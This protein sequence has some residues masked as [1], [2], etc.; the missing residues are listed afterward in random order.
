[1]KFN[2]YIISLFLLTFQISQAQEVQSQTEELSKI[3]EGNYTAYLTHKENGKYKG[4]MENLDYVLKSKEDYKIQPGVHQEIYFIRGGNPERRD[5]QTTLLFLPDNEA[6]PVTYIERFYEGNKEMQEELGYVQRVNRHADDNRLVFLDE[7]IYIIN[8]W[9]DKDH[10]DLEAVL[11]YEEKPI[12]M[13]KMMKLNM[14]SPK[15]MAELQPKEK[16][17]TYLDAASEKQKQ[18]YAQWISKPKNKALIANLEAKAKLMSKTITQMTDD[19]RNSE[20]Y[21]RILENN[22][23]ADE[24]QNRSKLTIVNNT[25]KRIQIRVDGSGSTS[26]LEAGQSSSFDCTRDIY[27]AFQSGSHTNASDVNTKIYSANQSCGGSLSID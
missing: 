20:E 14:K 5:S 18:V 11:E 9:E 8:N 1:M 13:L 23:M 24:A 15:K 26:A 4:G 12:G 16:L 3:K 7:H 2:F 27:Y 17:Q 10:Y 6:F 21:K 25:G 22:R 19:W